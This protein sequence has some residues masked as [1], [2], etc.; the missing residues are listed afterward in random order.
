MKLTHTIPS[1]IAKVSL[2]GVN[3]GGG[4][5]HRVMAIKVEWTGENDSLDYEQLE[6]VADKVMNYMRFVVSQVEGIDHG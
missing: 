2:E 4:D 6:E 5:I 3:G 1:V